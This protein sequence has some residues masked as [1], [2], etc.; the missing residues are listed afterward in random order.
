MAT[1]GHS[2]HRVL[3]IASKAAHQQQADVMAVKITY[4]ETSVH[5]SVAIAVQ[6]HVIKILKNALVTYKN[7]ARMVTMAQPVNTLVRLVVRIL[8]VCPKMESV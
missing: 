3:Q 5:Y 7:L 1:K 4:T 2:V 6:T 8:Y